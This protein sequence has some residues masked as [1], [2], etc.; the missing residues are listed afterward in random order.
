MVM[1]MLGSLVMTTLV[2][3]VGWYQ[4]RQTELAKQLSKVSSELKTSKNGRDLWFQESQRLESELNSKNDELE[5]SQATLSSFRW[6]QSWSDQSKPDCREF[7][8]GARE[9]TDAWVNLL[10]QGRVLVA[11]SFQPG[12]TISN[13]VIISN[14]SIDI[15]SHSRVE[16]C[17]VMQGVQAGPI[18][19]LKNGEPLGNR[20]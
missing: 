14:G 17:H 13:C 7:D 10:K 9:S 18:F 6:M 11:S 3:G 1:Y 20:P 8:D 4:S 12:T 16:N 19:K 15:S 5:R 2:F